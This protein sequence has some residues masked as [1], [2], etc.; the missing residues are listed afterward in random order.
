MICTYCMT[1]AQLRT[2]VG[3]IITLSDVSHSLRKGNSGHTIW[4]HA[5]RLPDL[6]SKYRYTLPIII[7][8]CIS[9]VNVNT[10]PAICLARLTSQ[11]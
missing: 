2:H 7:S 3:L 6:I 4:L 11:Y 9:R 1:N 8:L 10:H 5:G